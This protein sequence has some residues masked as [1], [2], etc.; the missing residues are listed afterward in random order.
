MARQEIPFFVP[1]GTRSDAYSAAIPVLTFTFTDTVNLEQTEMVNGPRTLLIYHNTAAP[2]G[3]A[4]AEVKSVVNVN[5][6]V[7]DQ[8]FLMGSGDAAV[9]GP[10]D[11]PG[12]LQAVE[13]KLFMISNSNLIEV[14]VIRLPQ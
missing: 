4:N 10:F 5:G 1:L 14:A 9:M 2:N 11:K 3:N 8:N 7:L 13:Q 6:R 12:F